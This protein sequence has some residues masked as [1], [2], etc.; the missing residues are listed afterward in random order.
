MLTE[1][2]ARIHRQAK[3]HMTVKDGFSNIEGLAYQEG[4]ILDSE[5]KALLEAVDGGR[6]LTALKRRVQH[7]GYKYNYA[8]R[9]V[10]ESD[11]LGDL[12]GWSDALLG[13][14][15][16][17][18]FADYGFD[19]LIVNEYEPGQGISAHIDCVPCFEDTVVVVSLGSGAEMLFSNPGTGQK[20][21]LYLKPGSMLAIRDE[22]RF[23]WKHAIPGR[24]SDVVEGVKIPRGRRV[25][26][27]FRK[28]K[29]SA[30]SPPRPP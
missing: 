13:R 17:E 15:G 9:T 30:A 20:I 14:I 4:F 5:E 26:L 16:R 27:T 7:Y 1:R 12:P 23:T 19:Q 18:G 25:S 21:A 10:E 11:Y 22:A 29:K 2:N 28:V 3:T 24:K 6:W 8:S